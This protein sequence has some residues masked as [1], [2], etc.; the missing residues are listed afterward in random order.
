MI[1]FVAIGLLVRFDNKGENTS[2]GA[3]VWDW[4]WLFI[5][6][7]E[8]L[9]FLPM[10]AGWIALWL[11]VALLVGWLFQSLV[12]IAASKHEKDKPTA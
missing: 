5:T 12:V 4:V 6:G 7:R 2:L 9:R 11:V 10:V 3:L 1:V 8:P